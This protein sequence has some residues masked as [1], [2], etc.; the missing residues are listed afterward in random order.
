LAEAR[1]QRGLVIRRTLNGYD[2]H[3]CF[4]VLLLRYL[5]D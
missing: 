2:G 1:R 3:D 4:D 5:L